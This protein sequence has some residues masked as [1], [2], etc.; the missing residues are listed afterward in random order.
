M[1]HRKLFSVNLLLIGTLLASNP[2]AQDEDQQ[3]AQEITDWQLRML[4]EG[5]SVQRSESIG[6]LSKMSLL[7]RHALLQRPNVAPLHAYDPDIICQGEGHDL[8]PLAAH[9]G[10]A[11][12]LVTTDTGGDALA[13]YRPTA[14]DLATDARRHWCDAANRMDWQ[15]ATTYPLNDLDENGRYV[16]WEVDLVDERLREYDERSGLEAAYADWS[17]ALDVELERTGRPPYAV[18]GPLNTVGASSTT[19]ANREAE[20][21]PR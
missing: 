7:F 11:A 19:P 8:L 2:A 15:F 13:I 12:I 4:S 9:R 1:T 5:V 16:S 21:G 10:S 17:D 3:R 20:S 14:L 18:E 6:F